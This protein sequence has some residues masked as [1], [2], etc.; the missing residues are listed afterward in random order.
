MRGRRRARGA[1]RPEELTKAPLLLRERGSGVAASGGAG[2]EEGRAAAAVSEGGDGAGFDGGYHLGG[3]RRSW[4]GVCF[5]LCGGKG[6]AAG[7]GEGGG[8]EGGWRLC[9]TSVLYGWRGQRQ[10]GLRRRFSGLQWG[11]RLLDRGDK[12][13]L[14]PI[15]KYVSTWVFETRML[16]VCGRRISFMPGLL[17]RAAD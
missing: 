1:I 6:V 14:S 17:L 15:G 11:R 13:Y 16:E 10:R 9:G 8:G 4:G 12:K 2:V 5:A 3:W 7:V